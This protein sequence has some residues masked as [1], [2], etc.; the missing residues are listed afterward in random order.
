M[1]THLMDNELSRAV[2]TREASR[3]QR[4]LSAGADPNAHDLFGW[5]PLIWAA[6]RGDA[7]MVEMLI[8][9]GADP[10]QPAVTSAVTALH[11]AAAQGQP[12]IGGALL[13]QPQVNIDARTS[14]G[15]TP[16]FWAVKSRQWEMVDWLIARGADGTAR[17]ARGDSPISEL[18]QAGR[19]AEVLQLLTPGTDVSGLTCGR[20]P[21]L[22][23]AARSSHR[24]VAQRLLSLNAP[25]EESDSCGRTPLA[26]A[27]KLENWEM[28]MLLIDAGAEPRLLD[29]DGE[30]CVHD[31]NPPSEVL[32]ALGAICERLV[33]FGDRLP[34]HRAAEDGRAN[35]V[36]WLLAHG[37]KAEAG[38]FAE[39][40]P[41]EIA[42]RH[43]HGEV[44]EVLLAA[45]VSV[46]G[47]QARTGRLAGVLAERRDGP[48]LD[49][50]VGAASAGGAGFPEFLATALNACVAARWADG[51]QRL[52][53][54]GA[55]PDDAGGAGSPLLRAVPAG[56][57][58]DSRGDCIR[59][60]SPLLDAG[61]SVE[62]T[63]GWGSGTTTALAVA[64]DRGCPLFAAMLAEHGANP[65]SR[66]QPRQSRDRVR[67]HCVDVDFWGRPVAASGPQAGE[68][69]TGGDEQD[70]SQ[71]FD[72][73]HDEVVGGAADLWCGY[74]WPDVPL[75]VCPRCGQPHPRHCGPEQAPAWETQ[76]ATS[77]S[78]L[79]DRCLACGQGIDDLYYPGNT[80]SDGAW[81]AFARTDL[82]AIQSLCQIATVH[83]QPA[84]RR[85]AVRAL[86][87]IVALE[88]LLE[89]VDDPRRAACL[90]A[91]RTYC[92]AYEPIDLTVAWSPCTDV[93]GGDGPAPSNE[94]AGH[95]RPPFTV[96]DLDRMVVP[97]DWGYDDLPY[98]A[99]AFL[100]LAEGVGQEQVATGR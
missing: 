84:D 2:R 71:T 21:V 97:E 42:V 90:E 25:L 86:M 87:Q 7:A 40:S 5:T 94:L 75:V 45:G 35:D 72:A 74:Q 83:P 79:P 57:E 53:E 11:A 13:T 36:E 60:G 64:T 4:L 58:E 6:Q 78:R 8:E 27:V 95:F 49:R 61:A 89:R 14:C 63:K 17:G 85:T 52:L 82:A 22:H 31:H 20:E 23:W 73:D 88:D 66:T 67:E 69:V 32:A 3:V 46:T 1:T 26:L 48:L 99:K 62:V 55:S 47:A 30:S 10:T 80:Y 39:A 9:R 92:S 59:I 54:A 96:R 41:L 56:Q 100:E 34:L 70:E 29:E 93:E 28:V 51:V 77:E 98:K 12:A 24:D 33:L 68:P 18:L 43:G 44:V 50:L 81:L 91:V 15:G 38:P 19:T 65:E 37:A 76:H 16:L